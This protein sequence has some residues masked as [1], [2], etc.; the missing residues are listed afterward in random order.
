[1]SKIRLNQQK[2][3]FE[4]VANQV[5]FKFEKNKIEKQMYVVYSTYSTYK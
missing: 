5:Q 3:Y 1:M 4:Y 2:K